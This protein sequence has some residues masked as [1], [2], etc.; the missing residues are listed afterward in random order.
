LGI[1]VRWSAEA[2]PVMTEWK[3]LGAGEYVCG[4]EPATHA[5]ASWEELAGKGLPR[6]LQP[7]ETVDY[8]LQLRILTDEVVY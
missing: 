3:M 7:G 5:L 1:L 2:M 6:I 8:E 4:L